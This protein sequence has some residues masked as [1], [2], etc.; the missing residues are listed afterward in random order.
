MIKT[1]ELYKKFG[2][3]FKDKDTFIKNWMVLWDIP[4][5]INKAIPALPN[6]MYCNKELAPKLEKVFFELINKG[7]HV[8]IKTF[9]GCFN[10]RKMRGGTAPSRHSWG[11]AIDLN[12]FENPYKKVLNNLY[13]EYRKRY[14]KWSPDFLQV[15]RDNNFVC[16]ADWIKVIDGMHFEPKI[17]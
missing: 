17:I 3:P 2:D 7:L 4:Q 10:I 12:A 1:A 8:E 11:I 15:W 5:D 6:K 13:T 16:G 14:V 9:D